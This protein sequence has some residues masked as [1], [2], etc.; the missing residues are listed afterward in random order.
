MLIL[1]FVWLGWR[2]GEVSCSAAAK[3]VNSAAETEMLSRVLSST[4]PSEKPDPLLDRFYLAHLDLS[5]PQP[6]STAIARVAAQARELNYLKRARLENLRLFPPGD[7]GNMPDALVSCPL[8]EPTLWQALAWFGAQLRADFSVTEDG[9]ITFTPWSEN[10]HSADISDRNLP[11]SPAWLEPPEGD[12]ADP[13][14][15][16]R[17]P[18]EPLDLLERWGID[19]TSSEL[20]QATFSRHLLQVRAGPA[21]QRQIAIL[22]QLKRRNRPA[23]LSV[24]LRAG[25]GGTQPGEGDRIVD[26]AGLSQWLAA[27]NAPVSK[28]VDG[29]TASGQTVALE[30]LSDITDDDQPDWRGLWAGLQLR[31]EGEVVRV[32]GTVEFRADSGL[33]ETISDE[34]EFEALVP[35]GQ[36]AIIVLGGGGQTE[37]VTAAAVTVH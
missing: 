12:S 6:L 30:L 18:L 4:E 20:V 8:V 33:G 24:S 14:A 21:V 13:A 27:Q 16:A 25:R 15:D 3:P 5:V 29:S 28:P 23:V 10:A 22:T 19:R 37:S 26:D 35:H 2:S 1:L 36:T 31:P 9:E 34:A 17:P 7:S 11:F 32:S